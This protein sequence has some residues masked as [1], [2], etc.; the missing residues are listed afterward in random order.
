MMPA[1]EAATSDML[2]PC[3]PC[4]DNTMRKRKHGEFYDEETGQTSIVQSTKQAKR[5]HR[6]QS[7]WY[8]EPTEAEIRAWDREDE[9]KKRAEKVERREKNKKINAL[10]RVEKEV[11]E[12][13]IKQGLF[14]SGKISFTQTLAKKD[15]DQSNLHKWF[16]GRPQQAELVKKSAQQLQTV[17]ET[18]AE[19]KELEPTN[20]EECE[21]VSDGGEQSQDSA[22]QPVFMPENECANGH[23]I[24]QHKLDEALA[25]A[26]QAL[27][28]QIREAKSATT[29]QSNSKIDN[30]DLLEAIP[31]DADLEISQ[32][33]YIAEDSDADTDILEEF[34]DAMEDQVEVEQEGTRTAT[35]NTISVFKVPALPVK[36]LPLSPMSPSQ[37][38]ARAASTS[39]VTSFKNKMAQADIN[40]PSSTQVVRD[41]LSGICTQD[42]ADDLDDDFEESFEDKENTDPGPSTPEVSPSKSKIHSPQKSSPLKHVENALVQDQNIC[43][44]L[45]T[46]DFDYD[47][48]FAE[49]D[50]TNSVPEGA[51]D[52]GF[53]DIDLDDES[54]L[55][56]PATQLLKA[57]NTN[58]PS[59][60]IE[61]T[62]AC[63][64]LETMGTKNVL[65]STAEA[66]EALVASRNVAREPKK[67]QVTKSDSF[68]AEADEEDGLFEAFV[69]YEQSQKSEKPSKK[70]RKLPWPGHDMTC[71]P[72]MC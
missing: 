40:I 18:G 33:F 71:E 57:A 49:L 25:K 7:K 54:L 31:D 34:D 64:A 46:Q 72:V 2:L 53:D 70:R 9:L 29:S 58:S 36:R 24:D 27:R 38:N 55:C 69:N 68:A 61:S 13:Q 23:R 1:I 16:G 14:D 21:Q 11:K 4:N 5:N 62:R 37:L 26:R 22:H 59:A 67:A 3:T 10:K 6:K 50:T 42:L 30:M 19:D 41:V 15:E 28:S 20:D 63:Q 44:F 51:E 60:A 45:P 32:D 65:P 47:D 8:K 17:E 43:A 66:Y 35:E 56:L 39:Q 12:Q 52:G 48:V